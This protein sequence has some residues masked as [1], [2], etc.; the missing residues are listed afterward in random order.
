MSD[1]CS[2]HE[3]HSGTWK[4]DHTWLVCLGCTDE[5]QSGYVWDRVFHPSTSIHLESNA[6]CSCRWTPQKCFEK[7]QT[8]LS[9]SALFGC[10]G[11]QNTSGQK[12]KRTG[13]ETLFPQTLDGH[14][15]SRTGGGQPSGLLQANHGNRRARKVRISP[16]HQLSSQT[17]LCHHPREH[18][19]VYWW[20]PE[21]SCLFTVPQC[22]PYRAR[23]EQ[24][25]HLTGCFARAC[26]SCAGSLFFFH[27]ITLPLPST[28]FG[29][30]IRPRYSLCSLRFFWSQLRLPCSPS[31]YSRNIHRL[32]IVLFECCIYTVYQP[33][34]CPWTLW[35][36]GRGIMIIVWIRLLRQLFLRASIFTI[37]RFEKFILHAE[38]IQVVIQVAVIWLQHLL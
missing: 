19:R 25:E 36:W 29:W 12:E 37:S 22:P 4:A 20:S 7:Q 27:Y 34:W 6:C 31:S 3:H 38:I 28:I 17:V 11:H 24:V 2:W 10:L 33:Q 23:Y 5:K 30:L 9:P 26:L 13:S 21:F 16:R 15:C 18:R 14:I 8:C 35:W 1:K 32:I